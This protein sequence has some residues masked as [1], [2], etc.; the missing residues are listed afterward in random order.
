MDAVISGRSGVALLMDGEEWRSFDVASFGT[1]VSR[2]QTDLPYLFGE[3]RDLKFLSN[4]HPEDAIR[5]LRVAYD[6]A[7]ALDLTLILLDEGS[8]TEIRT[9]AA[10]ELNDLLSESHVRDYLEAIFSA[11]PLPS[12]TDVAAASFICTSAGADKTDSFIHA[13]SDRQEDIRK[14]REE[15]DAIPID[16][17]NGYDARQAFE[18]AAVQSQLFRKLVDVSTQRMTADHFRIYALRQESITTQ[19]NHREVLRHWVESFR[20]PSLEKRGRTIISDDNDS[21]ETDRFARERRPTKIERQKILERVESKKQRIGQALHNRELERVRI[22]IDEL[23][24]YQLANGEPI[25]VVKSLCD[26][27]MDAKAA[28]MSDLQLELTERSVGIAPDDGWSWAQ[29]ADALFHLDRL[30]EALLAYDNA[31]A[32]G[33]QIVAQNGRAEVLKAQGQFEAAVSAYDAVIA[34]H[35]DDVFAQVGRAGVFKSQGEY[36]AA[37]GAYDT[38]IAHHPENVVAQTGRAA[39]L[40]AQGEY[41]AALEAYDRIILRHPEDVIVRTGRAEVLKAQGEYAA[42]LDAYDSILA[43]RPGDAFAQNGRAEVLKVQGKLSEAISAYESVRRTF[44][45]DRVARTGLACTLAAAHRFADALE[46]LSDDRLI[47]PDDWIDYHVRGMIFLRQGEVEKAIQIFEIGAENDPHPLSRDYFRGA[48]S[49][50]NLRRREFD[51]VLELLEHV[52]S[53]ALQPVADLARIHAFGEK[54]EFKR[55]NMAYQKLIV[56]PWGTLDPVSELQSRYI[57]RLGAS[58]SDEWVFDMEA[59]FVLRAA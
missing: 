46:L 21:L 17:F 27:A 37:L 54:G 2:R 39:V 34:L 12:G 9:E 16:V 10:A 8:E 26:L 6:C 33:A 40:K 38:V 50:A 49:I 42:A 5:E 55:A 51:R 43:F 35:S 25:H 20:I 41:A 57:S 3:A 31:T 47:N 29:Y 11:K 14:V 45:H 28:G 15:W 22:L 19:A 44:P 13:L 18:I 48:L 7:C 24:D 53:P 4:V 36:A 58:K 30:Q 1:F 56:G 52:S 23:V 32:F 59:E